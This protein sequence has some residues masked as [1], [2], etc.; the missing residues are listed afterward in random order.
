MGSGVVPSPG[1]GEKGPSL[2][3]VLRQVGEGE[4]W[5]RAWPES[6]CKGKDMGSQQERE[7]PK[8]EHC[9]RSR[10]G[11]WA[12]DRACSQVQAEEGG[13]G[14]GRVPESRRRRERE[15]LSSSVVSGLDGRENVLG[16][17][18]ALGPG[19]GG[20]GQ[21]SG[22]V[23]SLGGGGGLGSS[24]VLSPGG[25]LGLGC[26]PSSMQGKEGPRL[27]HSPKTNGWAW[28]SGV[29]SGRR[30]PGLSMVSSQGGERTSLGLSA[31]PGPGGKGR[32]LGLGVVSRLDGGERSWAWAWPRSSGG[33]RGLGSRVDLGLGGGVRGLGSSV[34]PSPGGGPGLGCGPS[35]IQGREEPKLECGLATSY[36]LVL[37]SGP[38]SKRGVLGLG[39]V[40][41]L[42]REGKGLGLSIVPAGKGGLGSGV[43]SGLG[44]EERG[45][46][47]SMVSGP[48]GGEG[49][50]LGHVL[51]SRRGKEVL[52]SSVV[53]GSSGGRRSKQEKEGPGLRNGPESR[54]R[55]GPRIER[56]QRTRQGGLGLDRGLVY[57]E[58]IGVLTWAYPKSRWGRKVLAQAWSRVQVGE[59]GA[60]TRAWSQG[61]AGEGR[62]GGALARVWF[63]NQ[64]G[65]PGARVWSLVQAWRKGLGS[66]VFL[67]P[68][69]GGDLG[70]YVVLSP[71]R[72][73][74]WARGWSRF[75]AGGPGLEHGPESKR[76]V[77]CLGVV[78]YL[79]GRGGP[80]LERALGSRLE[81]EGPGLKHGPRTRWMREGPGLRL[82][83]EYWW[84]KGAWARGPRLKHGPNSRPR[85]EGLGLSRGPEFRWRKGPG[86]DHCPGSRR[87]VLEFGMIL[88]LSREGR[89]LGSSM[90]LRPGGGRGL[91][92][93][94]GGLV[95][96]HGPESK[97][98]KEVL[99][100]ACLG[101]RR[102]EKGPRLGRAPRSRWGREGLGLGVV[103]VPG[104]G[105]MVLV[106]G[107]DP[108]SG[109]GRSLDSSV[110]SGPSK[111]GRDLGSS[112]LPG[113]GRGLSTGI[114][115]SLGR[116]GSGLGSG[117]VSGLGGGARPGI[118][119][120]REKGLGSSVVHAKRGREV[121]GPGVVL[122]P[123]G[124]MKG[125]GLGSSDILGLGGE[126]GLDLGMV[127]GPDGEGRGLGLGFI[128]GPGW[129][130]ALGL[131]LERVLRSHRGRRACWGVAWARALSR[132]QTKE[133][134]LG[135]GLSMSSS[136]GRRGGLGLGIILG[137][138]RGGKGLGSG[139]VPTLGGGR[140]GLGSGVIPGPGPSGEEV[141]RAQAWSLVRRRGLGSGMIL[142]AGDGGS[143]RLGCCPRSRRGSGGSN[144]VSSPGGVQLG[145]GHYPESMLGVG[146]WLE[147]GPISRRGMR[148]GSGVVSGPGEGGREGRGLARAWSQVQMGEKGPGL[149]HVLSSSGGKGWG[150]VSGGWSGLASQAYSQVQRWGEKR[151]EI[152]RGPESWC[153]RGTRLGLGPKSRHGGSWVWSWI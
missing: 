58:D 90:V 57:R 74:A 100:Q 27:E 35:S 63:C 5:F 15:I 120:G 77:L 24:V 66:S 89:G 123:K 79:D 126:G 28:G 30:G 92:N 40:L 116:R 17:S 135:S 64:V 47:S 110:I 33:G 150:L 8:I 22:M 61:Q 134:R 71:G 16:W 45:L 82:C 106:S 91:G 31:V 151:L 12:W 108:S 102:E 84:G 118:E 148:L 26:V 4:A 96:G 132:V 18:V 99:A 51:E 36:G 53:S 3:M 14:L 114:V 20:R 34:V 112:M 49:L 42:G 141:V 69:R 107:V 103:L 56:G 6:R 122:V 44:G 140:T 153:G 94:R 52:G 60:W 111:V 19:K 143:P 55:R 50:G 124:G 46:G 29:V 2:G 104:G 1:E 87:R 129:G 73:G 86:L 81:K 68:D 21:G 43:V 13:P 139:M 7:G 11:R 54:W 117:M 133:R 130:E 121:L 48:R 65:G 37:K 128:L 127:F 149:G 32:Y 23:L 152:N 88:V 75:Q 138:G 80:R 101:F 131:G 39:V 10:K 109:G 147:R 70:L 113:L 146:S 83:P 25:G 97:Q 67:S 105:G 125:S 136:P 93:R 72:G 95:L 137:P 98:K 142:S 144:V 76:R 78:L 85:R 115:P 41:G 145:L 119:H 62:K 9:P 59:E 38:G